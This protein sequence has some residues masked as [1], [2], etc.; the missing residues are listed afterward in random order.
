MDT[1]AFSSFPSYVYPAA[2]SI[3]SDYYKQILDEVEL[4]ISFLSTGFHVGEGMNE[5]QTTTVTEQRRFLE[6]LLQESEDLDAIVLTWLV[7]RDSEIIPERYGSL[8][9]SGLFDKE[10]SPRPS[11]AVWTRAS[12][13]PLA[14]PVLD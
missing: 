6:R 12:R 3:P 13:R 10:N 5:D 1:F 14:V 7:A 8:A 11:W 9:S 4:P 2:R